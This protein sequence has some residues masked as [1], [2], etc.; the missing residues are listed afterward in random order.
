MKCVEF[1]K[2]VKNGDLVK[3]LKDFGSIKIYTQL[4]K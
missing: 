3:M 4:I 2:P 1:R